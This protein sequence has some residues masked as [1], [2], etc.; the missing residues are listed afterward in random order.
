ME[1]GNQQFWIQKIGIGVGGPGCLMSEDP[2]TFNPFIFWKSI[3][4]WFVKLLIRFATILSIGLAGVVF[5]V[6]PETVKVGLFLTDIYSINYSDNH[7]TAQFWIWF[8]H[9]QPSFSSKSSIEIP[10][11]RRFQT[12]NTI[13]EER[14]GVFWDQA[15]MEATI[16]NTW[17]STYYPF[18][19]QIIKLSIEMADATSD[20]IRLEPDVTG[21]KIRQNLTI[22]GWRIENVRIYSDNQVYNTSY[23]DPGMNSEGPSSYSRITFELEIKREGWRLLF[24]DFVGFFFATSVAFFSLM[25]NSSRIT[26]VKVVPTVKMS[27][28][29]GSL[30]AAVGAAYV[31]QSRLPLT[32][33]FILADIIQLTAFVSTFLSIAETLLVEAILNVDGIPNADAT[34]K[35][36]RSNLA[37]KFSRLVLILVGLMLAVD[38][39]VL[40]QAVQS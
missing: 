21:S 14:N 34:L 23:G 26:F 1:E 20:K 16:G 38:I 3:T 35:L 24:N 39:F 37:L 17:N 36:R 8:N 28:S 10:N 12:L 7:Y 11:A 31:L 15:K 33:N 18:D 19:R 29:N 30:F 40:L 5:A 22:P 4:G 27:M 2:V 9:S 32:T 6:E 13:R 25:V